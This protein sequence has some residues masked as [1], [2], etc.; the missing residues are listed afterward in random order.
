MKPI[1][2]ML[3]FV[4]F[5]LLFVLAFYPILQ[6][7]TYALLPEQNARMQTDALVNPAVQYLPFIGVPNA[8]SWDGLADAFSP[9]LL[10][11]YANSLF[12]A[13]TI[14]LCQLVISF[15]VAFHLTVSRFKFKKL[16]FYAY[17]LAM[18]LPFQVTLVPSYMIFDALGLLDSVWVILLPG[19]FS[20]FGVFLFHQF[21]RQ[22]DTEVIDAA[23][24]DGANLFVVLTRIVAPMVR[25]GIV[26]FLLLC[27]NINWAAI[28]PAIAFLRTAE[29]MPFGIAL[30]DMMNAKPWAVYAPSLLYV[31]PSLLLYGW[32]AWYRRRH[33]F[34]IGM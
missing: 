23:K 29:K 4:F 10:R 15:F 26:V 33:E 3:S 34:S 17:V 24:L 30:R 28:E 1:R 11:Q 5:A 32:F 20:P 12:Y 7:I 16:F 14:T 8:L 19:M 31:V 25:P 22:V 27:F 13:L 9:L 18:V 6:L 21:M 2:R